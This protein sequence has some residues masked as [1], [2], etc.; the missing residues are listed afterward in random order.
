MRETYFGPLIKV[1][2]DR[3]EKEQK[4]KWN[5]EEFENNVMGYSMRTDAYRLIVWKN[6]KYPKQAPLGIELYDLKNN[7][8]ETENIADENPELV[9][10]LMEQFNK[11]WQ[12]SIVGI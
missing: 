9:S 8:S 4:E 6:K 11:G 5:K 7:I 2:E 12:G 10:Q 1:M 3:I